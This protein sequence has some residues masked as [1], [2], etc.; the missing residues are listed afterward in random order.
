MSLYFSIHIQTTLFNWE[1]VGIKKNGARL[2]LVVMGRTA[3]CSL[4]HLYLMYH[5]YEHHHYLQTHHN[6]RHHHHHH[7]HYEGGQVGAS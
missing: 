7:H 1:K 5:H 3:L 4:E 2:H 6:H